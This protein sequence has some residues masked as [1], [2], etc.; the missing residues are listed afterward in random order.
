MK[1]QLSEVIEMSKR[2]YEDASKEIG[3]TPSWLRN[4]KRQDFSG[5]IKERYIDFI[6]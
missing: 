5:K 3:N 2:T 6:E 1:T 4:Y